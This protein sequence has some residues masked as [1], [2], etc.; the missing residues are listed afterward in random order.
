MMS[1]LKCWSCGA[2]E[3]DLVLKGDS[4]YCQ[5]CNTW[6]GYCNFS[7]DDKNNRWILCVD[8]AKDNPENIKLRWY[9]KWYKRI[10]SVLS[11]KKTK[12]K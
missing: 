6:N 10:K 9:E 11:N 2:D 4:I 8:W 5:E 7:I 12:E 1:E 3:D